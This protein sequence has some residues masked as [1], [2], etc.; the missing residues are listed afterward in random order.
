[1]QTGTRTSGT[2]SRGGLTLA[3]SALLI[4][5]AP[6]A[7][8]MA[9]T[10][11]DIAQPVEPAAAPEMMPLGDASLPL[12]AEAEPAPPAVT[13]IGSGSASY[14]A[15]KFHGRRTASGEAFDNGAMTAAHRTLPFGSLVRVTNPASGKSVTVRI[16]DR[17]P[18]SRGRVIDVSRA[19][20]EE[21]GLVSRGHATVELAL[22]ED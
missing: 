18:F 11:A 1:M 19:A 22:I 3:V 8:S 2:T 6:F 15:S 9:A 7:A 20:A 10:P 4:A 5:I 16:N 12:P 17:G 21:L 13:S 14:Y